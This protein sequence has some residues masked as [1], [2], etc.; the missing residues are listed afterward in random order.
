MKLFTKYCSLALVLLLRFGGQADDGPVDRLIDFQQYRFGLPPLEF[1]FDATGAH[2]A[3][4][5]AR[6]PLWRTYIDYTAPS[7]KFVLIEAAGLPQTNHFPIALVKETRGA[8][9]KLA[10]SFKLL[11][12]TLDRSAGL[13]WSGED[14]NN[15][16][17]VLASGLRQNVSFV[18]MSNGAPVLLGQA[19]FSLN[20]TNWNDIEVSVQG[21]A[22]QVWL[23][24]KLVLE[25]RD[26]NPSPSGQVG[27]IT[28]ADSVVLFDDLYIQSG[29]GRV[30]RKT[31]VH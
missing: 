15:Y 22:I 24:N 9:L 27:L 23:N 25:N 6:R 30:I 3:V 19:S 26:K 21:E 1:V 16:F 5:A 14:R 7:P 10:V 20:E 17:G 29:S 18:Q 12:G 31:A 2:G 11:S 4:L 28:A 13:L 8:E